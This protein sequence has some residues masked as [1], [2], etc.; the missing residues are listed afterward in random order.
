MQT[1]DK[2]SSCHTRKKY[3]V[4]E[5]GVMHPE[6][7]PT[8]SLRPGQVGYIA[9]NMK[10]SAEGTTDAF[11]YHNLNVFQLILAIPYFVLANPWIQCL[12]FNQRKQWQ[13]FRMFKPNAL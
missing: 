9:C 3:E 11:E 12:V 1:G 2:I 13:V 8:D 4:T 6:E 5:L 7:V 10:E